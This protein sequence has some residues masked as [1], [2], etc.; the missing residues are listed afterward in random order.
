MGA[1]LL[2]AAPSNDSNDEEAK[3][4]VNSLT[5]PETREAAQSGKF[6]DCVLTLSATGNALQQYA[7][8]SALESAI[9]VAEVLKRRFP[10]VHQITKVGMLALNDSYEPKEEYLSEGLK[11]VTH[12]RN[13]G[14]IEIQL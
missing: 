12:V 5:T 9:T 10:N 7:S 14:F 1:A 4:A 3:A 11:P 8:T 2:W 13:V 6:K